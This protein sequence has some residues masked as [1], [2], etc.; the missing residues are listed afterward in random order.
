M[1]NSLV[2]SG[3]GLSMHA[4]NEAQSW[5]HV[6]YVHRLVHT[7]FLAIVDQV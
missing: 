5:P 7:H 2:A 3:V 1:T 4:S 6:L